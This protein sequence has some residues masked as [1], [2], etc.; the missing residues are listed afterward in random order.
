MK[1][2][3]FPLKKK[4]IGQKNIFKIFVFFLNVL[5]FFGFFLLNLNK[6]LKFKI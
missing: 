1:N 5:F 6:F 4:N 3:I 2:E